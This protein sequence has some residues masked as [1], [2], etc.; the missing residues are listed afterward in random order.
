MTS[1]LQ[2]FT[3]SMIGIL[4]PQLGSYYFLEWNVAGHQWRPA[5]TIP[6]IT[7]IGTS[8]AHDR[9]ATATINCASGPRGRTYSIG[10]L[11]DPRFLKCA[12][13][14]RVVLCKKTSG[15]MGQYLMQVETRLGATIPTDPPENIV[16]WSVRPPAAPAPDQQAQQQQRAQVK[17]VPLTPIPQRI[18]WLIADDA[19]KNKE[20]CSISL[21]EISP[22]TAAVTTCFHCFDADS[23]EGWFA[24]QGEKKP[25]PLCR[26]ECLATKAFT[27]S[28]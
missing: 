1:A 26:T 4:R 14:S 28:L 6:Q 3:G 9:S 12:N 17:S 18:A 7:S 10:I 24:T 2:N 15:Q 19:C 23:L 27:E 11:A 5:I 20:S 13:G 22:L 8:T 25:C 16:L 21:E